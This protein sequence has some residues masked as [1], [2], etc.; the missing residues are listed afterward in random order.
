MSAQQNGSDIPSYIRARHSTGCPHVGLLLSQEGGCRAGLARQRAH[1][2]GSAR[3]SQRGCSDRRPS[4]V[5]PVQ[6]FL[7]ISGQLSAPIEETEPVQC[8]RGMIDFP[9]TRGVMGGHPPG[10]VEIGGGQQRGIQSLVRICGS[11]TTGVSALETRRHVERERRHELPYWGLKGCAGKGMPS[12]GS[13]ICF[14]P[15][16]SM[17]VP[18]RVPRSMRFSSVPSDG[19]TSQAAGWTARHTPLQGTHALIHIFE[20]MFTP[21]S[22]AHTPALAG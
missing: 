22:C 6:D 13:C 19:R 8:R 18:H 9:D 15:E 1:L 2:S 4:P 12:P 11:F 17:T 5:R 3:G 16:G 10:L 14:P 7:G 21:Q 20:P